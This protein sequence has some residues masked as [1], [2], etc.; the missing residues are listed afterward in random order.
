V[1]GG[2][3]SPSNFNLS[4]QIVLHKFIRK[5]IGIP[6]QYPQPQVAYEQTSLVT[7]YIGHL[8]KEKILS[9]ADNGLAV[10]PSDFM[11][12]SSV[13]A[14]MITVAEADTDSLKCCD[15]A[16]VKRS[17]MQK[18]EQKM[19][20]VTVLSDNETA[21]WQ[22]NSLRKP[23]K[24]DPTCEFRGDVI[25]FYPRNLRSAYLSYIRYPLTPVWNYTGTTYPV[26]NP[27]GSVDIELPESCADELMSMMLQRLGMVIREEGM[28]NFGRYL[29]ESGL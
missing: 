28:I 23:T 12:Q 13:Y 5:Y 4:L 8:K 15:T 22:T 1:S 21:A 14:S 10:K 25:Q 20:P 26:F 19:V 17:T 2:F 24:E 6:E 9:I 29:K 11:H 18:M 27:T 16:Q 7:D 3:I